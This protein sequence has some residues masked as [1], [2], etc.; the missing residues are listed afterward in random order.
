MYQFSYILS[1]IVFVNC[2]DR[3]G[4]PGFGRTTAVVDQIIV[5]QSSELLCFCK[6]YSK[7]DIMRVTENQISYRL[8]FSAVVF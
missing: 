3:L 1:C 8:G 7:V 4:L 6:L 5:Q 2:V